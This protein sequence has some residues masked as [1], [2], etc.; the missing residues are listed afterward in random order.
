MVF[1]G[2][3]YFGVQHHC[4]LFEISTTALGCQRGTPTRR[5]FFYQS[6]HHGFL[7]YHFLGRPRCTNAAVMAFW[8]SAP[9][10][11]YPIPSESRF[12]RLYQYAL[13]LSGLYFLLLASCYRRPIL[14]FSSL[15]TGFGRVVTEH[16][17][18]LY[19]F[20]VFRPSFAPPVGYSCTV[21]CMTFV[22]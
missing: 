10:H 4:S 1:C 22:Q 17:H 15:V 5:V 8:R 3:D 2:I 9:L 6:L 11:D 20:N 19:R 21:A 7:R 14:Q 12:A 18:S 16:H 13:T